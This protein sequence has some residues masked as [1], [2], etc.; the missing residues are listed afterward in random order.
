M[1]VEFAVRTRLIFGRACALLLAKVPTSF[2]SIASIEPLGR[3]LVMRTTEDAEISG[4]TFSAK[5]F[6]LGMV[7]LEKGARLA[8]SVVS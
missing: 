8:V 4:V 5:P 2:H 3:E 1:R 7:E 6:G